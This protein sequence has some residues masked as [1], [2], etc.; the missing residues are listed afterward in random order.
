MFYHC[1][2]D[3]FF[4]NA[5]QC[6]LRQA[7]LTNIGYRSTPPLNKEPN[8]IGLPVCSNIPLP[9]LRGYMLDKAVGSLRP[10]QSEE[11]RLELY[12][13]CIGANVRSWM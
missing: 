4:F 12:C 5:R 6:I 7:D 1:C 2:T 10:I 8:Q 13:G 11:I 3:S 9:Q